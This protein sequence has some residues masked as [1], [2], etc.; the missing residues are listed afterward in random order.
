MDR[1]DVAYLLNSTPKYFY[2]LELHVALLRRYAPHCKWPVYFATE[3]PNDPICKVLKSYNVNIIA[4]EK[5]NSSF[6]ASRRRALE[7][8]PDSIQY[9]LP[10]QEDFLLE[11]YIDINAI[12]DS[13]NI[14]DN[15]NDTIAIRYMPCPGPKE[16]NPNVGKFWKLFQQKFDS[17]LFSFQ[18]TM[19][20]KKYCLTYYKIITHELDAIAI[21]DIKRNHIEVKMNIAENSDGQNLYSYI[22]K[23]KKTLGYIR[24]HKYPNA[25][26]MSP[27]PYRPT[28]IVK[29]KLQDFAKELGEREGFILKSV[30]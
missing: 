2:I 22:F 12:E 26:Y 10:M 6:L 18:A 21:E 15:D 19:W 16:I 17:Y 27:W 7:L 24:A 4:L 28:A 8:L 5:E 30:T 1:Q 13:L 11:R 9:V 25:V 3:Y 23:D 14:L 29:G 20:K